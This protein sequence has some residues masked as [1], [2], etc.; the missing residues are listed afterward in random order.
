M[1]NFAAAVGIREINATCDII[2]CQNAVVPLERVLGLCA[3]DLDKILEQEPTFLTPEADEG[4]N[5]HHGH[6]SEQDGHGH[7]HGHGHGDG[8]EHT[9]DCTDEDCVDDAGG[10]RKG[11]AEVGGGGGGAEAT[12]RKHAHSTA[13]GSHSIILKGSLDL[14]KLNAF[15]SILLRDKGTCGII[16]CLHQS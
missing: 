15:I 14:K 6:D 11:K 7:G 10:K 13:V 1:R 2:K 8:D 12:K 16:V 9:D 5:G 4:D 3:F